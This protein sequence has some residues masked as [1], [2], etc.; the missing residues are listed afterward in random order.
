MANIMMKQIA[1]TEKLILFYSRE[2]PA[3]TIK[4]LNATLYTGNS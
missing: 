4:K 2:H 1:N 3:E